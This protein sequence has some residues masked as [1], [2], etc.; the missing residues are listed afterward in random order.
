MVM[1]KSVLR[2]IPTYAMSYLKLPKMI[3]NQISG[4]IRKFWWNKNPQNSRNH[5]LSWGKKNKPYANTNHQG[6]QAFAT[7]SP[8]IRPWRL[9]KPKILFLIKIPCFHNISKIYTTQQRHFW[10][11]IFP[12]MLQ[13]CGE[14]SLGPKILFK[15]DVD[16]GL[17]VVLPYTFGMTIDCQ[18][19][20]ISTL[21]QSHQIILT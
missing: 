14:L 11:L 13:R 16:G 12:R 9:S 1:I 2:S 6:A 21:L 8:L 5:F 17:V 18:G 10:I 19:K 3:C 20:P 15:W 7:S 4:A